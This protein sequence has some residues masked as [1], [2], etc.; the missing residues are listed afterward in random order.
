MTTIRHRKVTRGHAV[1]CF[2]DSIAV[3]VIGELDAVRRADDAVFVVVGVVDRFALARVAV[4]VVGVT[5]EPVVVA[6]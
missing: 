5:V 2:A 4:A 1:D 3:A 6:V